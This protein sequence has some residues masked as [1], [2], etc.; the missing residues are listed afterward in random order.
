MDNALALMIH[1][2]VSYKARRA[3]Q[4]TRREIFWQSSRSAFVVRPVNST[5][6]RAFGLQTWRKRYCVLKGPILQWL[7]KPGGEVKGEVRWQC[8]YG[9]G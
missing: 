5:S 1:G 3:L 8:W 4:G 7:S 9:V 2:R 6:S